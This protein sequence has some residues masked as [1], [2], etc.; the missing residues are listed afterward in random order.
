[1][2]KIRP[3]EIFIGNTVVSK[4]QGYATWPAKILDIQPHS[5][6]TIQ[7]YHTLEVKNVGEDQIHEFLPNLTKLCRKTNIRMATAFVCA[8]AKA[9]ADRFG[10]SISAYPNPNPN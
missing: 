6:I 8:I 10:V 1:M 9:I 3:A 5:R 4:S 7:Y 2:P